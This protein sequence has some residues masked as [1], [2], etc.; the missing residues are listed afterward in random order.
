[1]KILIDT[2]QK[3]NMHD[4]KHKYLKELGIEL[5]VVPLPVG[6]YILVNDAVDDVLK[7]KNARGIKV[8]KMDLLGS[9]K[10]SVDTK[11]DIQEIVGNICGNQ[12]DRFRDE[13]LLAKNNGIKLYI[14][15]E[16]EDGV[17]CLSDLYRWENPR[18]KMQKWI[19]TASGRR[20]KVPVSEK[21][22]KGE[23][24]A[25]AMKTME[26]KYGCVFVFCRPEETGERILELLQMKEA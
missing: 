15:V 7:R 16:N 13:V 3:E 23:T 14:L 17:S 8:K 24:L 26:D 5:E 25:K 11:R 4:L 22:T 9:Y 10:V 21:A 12:H 18:A 1:M 2:G 20:R 6:D 19:T